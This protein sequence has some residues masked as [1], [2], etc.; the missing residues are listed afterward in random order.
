MKK[1]IFSAILFAT[2]TTHSFAQRLSKEQA[3]ADLQF[4][5]DALKVAHPSLYRYTKEEEYNTIYKFLDARIQDSMAKEDLGELVNTLVSTARCAHTSASNAMKAKSNMLFNFPV[6]I[7]NHK[8]YARSIKENSLDTNLVRI[9]SINKIPAIEIIDRMMMLKTGDGFNQNFAEAFLSQ[10]FNTFYNVLYSTP[11]A[12]AIV[13]ATDKGT[14]E[15]TVDRVK[16]Y[17]SKYKDYEWDGSNT[18]DTMSGIRLLRLKNIPDTRVLRVKSFKRV[19]TTF[20]KN[21]FAAMKRDSVKQLV[22]DLRGNTGGNIDHA[23][24]LLTNLI[25]K[26]IYMYTERRKAKVA[27]YL[28]WKGKAEWI[29]GKILYDAYPKGQRWSDDNGLKYYR[30]SFKTID[31]AHFNP[32]IVVITDGMTISSGSLVAAYLK[33]YNNAEVIGSESGGTYTGNNGRSFPEVLL[34]NSKIN[35]RLPLFYI[36]YFPGV[37]NYGRGVAVDAQINPL[38]DRKSQEQIIQNQLL[39]NVE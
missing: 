14:K 37:P 16:K 27:P 1:I 6:V 29:L 15:L 20:Y 17:S 8:L 2:I 11:D 12:C 38:L 21:A 22:I 30:Y 35:V 34:P 32:H 18:V 10:N 7:Y 26:D 24:Y 23:F 25:D 36:N 19:N 33:Y 13:I 9:I 3:K 5:Y 39:N 4:C 31:T 28:S